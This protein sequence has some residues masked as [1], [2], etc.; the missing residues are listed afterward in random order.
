MGTWNYS[1]MRMPCVKISGE[2]G[3]SQGSGY[4]MVQQ[5]GHCITY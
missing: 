1:R 3:E 4:D 5:E 2:E